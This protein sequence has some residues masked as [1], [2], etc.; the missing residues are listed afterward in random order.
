MEL[1]MRRR[2][3]EVGRARKCCGRRIVVFFVLDIVLGEL[4]EML[5][6]SL[7]TTVDV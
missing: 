6:I 4:T 5:E 2:S 1:D 7:C 3:R